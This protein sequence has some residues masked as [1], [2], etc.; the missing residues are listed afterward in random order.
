MDIEQL[1]QLVNKCAVNVVTEL[2]SGFLEAVYHKALL[3]ELQEQGITNFISE[4]PIFVYYKGQQIGEYKADI[5]I[6]NQLIVE[7][8]AVNKLDRIHEVQLVHYLTA[9][10]IDNGLLINFGS[11]KIEIKRKFR[12]YKTTIIGRLKT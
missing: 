4:A 5:I 1:I 8:K 7:L 12:K 10:N 6:E 3:I 9:T 2:G 11:P